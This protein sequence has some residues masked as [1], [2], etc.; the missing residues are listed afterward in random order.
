MREWQRH[1]LA[2]SAGADVNMPQAAGAAFSTQ[3]ALVQP[4]DADN[5]VP[6]PDGAT[7]S[8]SHAASAAL[9]N[10]TLPGTVLD[11]L[12]SAGGDHTLS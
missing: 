8:A 4:E 12:Q 11:E 7:L 9:Q 6:Q 5:D 1:A 3:T 10:N 2:Y